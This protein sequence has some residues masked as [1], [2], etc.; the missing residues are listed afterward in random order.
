MYC[1]ATPFGG[2]ECFVNTYHAVL[3]EQDLSNSMEKERRKMNLSR[4]IREFSEDIQRQAKTKE[5]IY[6]SLHS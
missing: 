6:T 4:K 2:G 1:T 3:Q 5:G